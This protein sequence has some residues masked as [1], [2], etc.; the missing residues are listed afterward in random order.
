MHEVLA[1]L[2]KV[3][4]G[5]TAGLVHCLWKLGDNIAFNHGDIDVCF[6]ILF[7]LRLLREWSGDRHGFEWLLPPV[8]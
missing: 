1:G 8:A 6:T 4:L 2:D 7:I 3:F 5:E